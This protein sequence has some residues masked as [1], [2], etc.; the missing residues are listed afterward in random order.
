MTDEPRKKIVEQA[1]AHLV[2]EDLKAAPDV[3]GELHR[4]GEVVAIRFYQAPHDPKIVW[5]DV[6][7]ATGQEHPTFTIMRQRDLDLFMINQHVEIIVRQ[8]GDPF[9]KDK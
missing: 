8:L 1:E 9:K 2:V 4:S 3:E 5:A 7:I 6:T